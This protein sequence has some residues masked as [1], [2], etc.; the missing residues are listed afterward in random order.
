MNKAAFSLSLLHPKYL[1]TWL[2][3]G[4][5]WCMVNLLPLS[6]LH[7]LGN[8]LGPLVGK[9]I[10]KR[11]I[12][13]KK[14]IELCFPDKPFTE[15]E[16]IYYQS[17]QA[18][19]RSIFESCAAWFM[20][21]WR[22]KRMYTIDGLE[23]VE[24]LVQQGQGA[25][26][27]GLHFTTI[28]I[29]GAFLNLST[30][31]DSFYRPNYNKAFDYVQRKGRERHNSERQAIPRNDVRG[32]IKSL[33][34]GRIIIYATDQD[35]GSKHSIFVPFFNIPTATITAPSD[36]ANMSHVGALTYTS[37]WNSVTKRYEIKI[38]PPLSNFPSGNKE[39]DTININQFVEKSIRENPGQYLWAHRRFKTR[40][41]GETDFYHVETA[42]YKKKR[43]KEYQ[44]R[45]KARSA[46][47]HNK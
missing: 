6:I 36:I 29:C 3:I 25:L 26:F 42:R 16:E 8:G 38:Y 45:M 39:V 23:H 18:A 7:K 11:G 5:L 37:K 34:Q 46:K 33:K 4:L 31:I 27:I 24:K 40:P 28:D 19:G 1:L 32:M 41:D 2:G 35:Y 22:L 44:Q 17:M 13:A 12:I 20:P 10:K 9:I 15:R 30:S 47:S 21:Q 14:N 43:I